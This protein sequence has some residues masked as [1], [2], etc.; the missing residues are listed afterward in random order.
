MAKN[1]NK[2]KPKQNKGQ[3]N[4]VQATT[5]DVKMSQPKGQGVKKDNQ[6][7]DFYS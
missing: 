3:S 2:E 6:G 1:K 5:A 7:K 4:D